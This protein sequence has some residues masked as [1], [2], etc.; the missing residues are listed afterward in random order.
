MLVPRRQITTKRYPEMSLSQASVLQQLYS[1]MSE[2]INEARMNAAAW[3]VGV[4]GAQM[5]V[6][7]QRQKLYECTEEVAELRKRIDSVAEQ[8]TEPQQKCLAQLNLALADY[9]ASA[10]RSEAC[11][12]LLEEY[13]ATFERKLA[14]HTTQLDAATSRIRKMR[15]KA[16]AAGDFVAKTA[17]RR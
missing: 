6:A 13:L 3:S 14:T 7:Q 8:Q 5:V 1:Q 9:G 16:P 4:A 12:V 10:E 17:K 15:P 11:L 2:P